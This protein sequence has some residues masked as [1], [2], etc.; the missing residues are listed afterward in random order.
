MKRIEYNITARRDKLED[1]MYEQG[2]RLRK[3]RRK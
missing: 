3:K 2:E 1:D